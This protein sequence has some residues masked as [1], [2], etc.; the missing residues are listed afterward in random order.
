MR[1]EHASNGHHSPERWRLEGS[2]ARWGAAFVG[3]SKLVLPGNTF[4]LRPDRIRMGLDDM[5]AMRAGC[6]QHEPTRQ[7]AHRALNMFGMLARALITQIRQRSA[8]IQKGLRR[9]IRRCIARAQV[10]AEA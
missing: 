8:C 5:H 2:G 9:R 4:S 6:W 10:V 7:L 3:R 1:A